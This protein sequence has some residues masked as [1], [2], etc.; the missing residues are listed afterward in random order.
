[1]KAPVELLP[2]VH[3]S[4]LVLALALALVPPLK[5]SMKTSW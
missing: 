2:L 3:L 4:E 1:V 5:A